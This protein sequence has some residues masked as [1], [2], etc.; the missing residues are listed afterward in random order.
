VI[1]TVRLLLIDKLKQ[2]CEVKTAQTRNGVDWFADPPTAPQASRMVAW[3]SLASAT[4]FGLIVIGL[5]CSGASF[6]YWGMVFVV[7][8]THLVIQAAL[9]AFSWKAGASFG[10]IS[11]GFMFVY[12]CL[13]IAFQYDLKTLSVFTCSAVV[14]LTATKIGIRQFQTKSAG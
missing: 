11:L 13:W 9:S 1:G 2:G 4:V 8:S 14:S 7:T 3:I 12:A 10:M 6:G 5:L